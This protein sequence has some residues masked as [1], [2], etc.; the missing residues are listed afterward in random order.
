MSGLFFLLVLA[1]WFLITVWLGTKIPKWFG[2]TRYRKTVSVLLV[3][4]I[5]FAPVA[6]EIIAYPQM[7]AMCRAGRYEL[8]VAENEAYGR[9]IY[10]TSRTTQDTLWPHTV[11]IARR[12]VRYIDATTKQPVVIGRGVSPV[13][14]FLS[15]PGGSS[16][17]KEPLILRN[18]K[19]TEAL[20]RYGIPMR[21]SHLKFNV[22]PTP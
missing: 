12:E 21:F 11:V 16:G 14:G 5:F 4:L 17:D 2:L 20:D 10:Y 8:A 7:Q 13:H 3:L 6:D 9:M 1:L 18:C 22:V 19:G 15:V